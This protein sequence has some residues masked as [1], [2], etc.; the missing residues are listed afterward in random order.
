MPRATRGLVGAYADR[1]HGLWLVFM[2]FFGSIF[3]VSYLFLVRPRI[4]GATE[5]AAQAFR[6]S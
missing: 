5:Q 3:A 4:P 6:K 2:F 1:N